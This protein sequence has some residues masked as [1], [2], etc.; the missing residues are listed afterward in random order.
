MTR[1][2]ELGGLGFRDLWDFN[3]AMITK[4]ASRLQNNLR[5]LWVLRDANIGA[6]PSWAWSSILQGRDV[7][8]RHGI[9]QVGAGRS[10]CAFED[11]WIP[12]RPD[13]TLRAVDQGSALRDICVSQLIA[14][15]PRRWNLNPIIGEISKGEKRAI[16]AIYLSKGAVAD[17]WVCNRIEGE[18]FGRD[19]CTKLSRRRNVKKGG[20]RTEKSSI[21]PSRDGKVSGRAWLYQR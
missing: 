9:W 3:T 7:M 18:R 10:I 2:K 13:F 21:G 6:R 4:T 17:R 12:G 11:R 5:A 20:F 8:T 14:T 1:P 15:E 19:G 16:Q